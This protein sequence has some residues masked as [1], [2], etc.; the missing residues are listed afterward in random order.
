M[1]AFMTPTPT[2][3]RTMNRITMIPIIT[4]NCTFDPFKPEKQCN[5]K[6]YDVDTRV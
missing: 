6:H 3:G 1:A 5:R 2:S 4:D